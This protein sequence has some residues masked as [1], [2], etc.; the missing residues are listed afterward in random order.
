MVTDACARNDPAE[1]FATT[2]LGPMTLLPLI[3]QLGSDLSRALPPK[4]NWL[5]ACLVRLDPRDPVLAEVLPD[6]LQQLRASIEAQRAV[7]RDPAAI[8]ALS[9]LH[10]LVSAIIQRL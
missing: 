4:L 1:V 3:Q 5:H 6:V 10:G 9:S 8:G 7:E 2:N